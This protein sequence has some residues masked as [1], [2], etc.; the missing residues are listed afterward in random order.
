MLPSQLKP[1]DFAA[2]PPQARRIAMDNIV[3]LQQLPLAFAGALL[4]EVIAYDW[5]FPA[6]R[7]QLDQQLRLLSALSQPELATR[8]EG[9]AAIT[10]SPELERANW[11]SNPS[12]FMEQLTALLW[13]THQMD[14]F[15]ATADTYAAY[16]A[17]A[18][19]TP[20]PTMPRLGIVVVGKDV[21][22]DDYPLFRKLRP[23]GVRL[24]RIRPEG[25]LDIL[26]SAA[27]KR[28]ENQSSTPNQPE[29][30]GYS[31]WYIDG[32]V[33]APAAFLT[34]VS[35][36]GL[37]GSRTQLLR[38]T[39]QA[40][41]SAGIGPEA[42]RSMLAEMKP[43]D[44]GLDDKTS[45]PVLNHFKLSLLT[46]GSGTQIFSTTFVQ[47]AARECLRRAQP[48]T[49]LLRYA[50]RQEQQPMNE[51]LSG[52]TV[53]AP[54]R[55]GSLVDADMGAYYTWLNMNRLS[56]ADQMSFL[57]WYEGHAEGVAIGPGLPQGTTS[58]SLMDMHQVLALLG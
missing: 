23:H 57:V 38:K 11:V 7:H 3:L 4:R 36:E 47:W 2:Y 5:H 45:D 12:G 10:L 41:E 35:Y 54:D 25:G 56:G 49:L 48:Q 30:A 1:A 53:G 6:E 43:G 50:P 32:G 55:H 27:S 24:K 33:A 46:E 20:R 16:L 13:G 18:T 21:Q 31:H 28:A 52:A 15:R 40:I 26:L 14:A 58:D 19:P 29:A 44:V 22:E 37:R 39:R 8:M 51:M 9:F 42:L 34:Q 17:Q